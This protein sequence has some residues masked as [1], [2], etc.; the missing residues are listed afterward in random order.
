MLLQTYFDVLLKATLRK[1]SVNDTSH[2]TKDFHIIVLF[3]Y[4]TL[5]LHLKK[6]L[7]GCNYE[8]SSSPSLSIRS[9][10]DHAEVQSL[11]YSFHL[12]LFPVFI[13]FPP[14]V[15]LACYFNNSVVLQYT[16]TLSHVHW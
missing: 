15:D 14:L 4:I 6:K 9:C 2:Y 7:T 13:F 16:C 8:L 11:I 5:G 3:I 12:I 1:M 10:E